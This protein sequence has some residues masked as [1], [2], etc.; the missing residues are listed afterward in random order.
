MSEIY[1]AFITGVFSLAVGFIGLSAGR[2]DARSLSQKQILETQ[3]SCVLE[4]IEK[5][6]NFSQPRG[7]LEPLNS[8]V[9]IVSANY[10]LVPQEIVREMNALRKKQQLS[11]ADF[12]K[13]KTV[14][15]SYY[16]WTCKTLGYPYDRHQIRLEYTPNSRMKI[17]LVIISDLLLLLLLGFSIVILLLASFPISSGSA[18]SVPVWVLIFCTYILALGLT[19]IFFT[20]FHRK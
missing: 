5:L 17:V 16:N 7:P 9:N 11:E 15:S 13:L 2:K 12:L 3:L 8:L 14:V 1:G 6:F 19:W 20:H 4:P 10:K 18:P